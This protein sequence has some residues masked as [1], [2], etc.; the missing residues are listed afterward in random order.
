M[1]KSVLLIAS[2][3]AHPPFLAVWRLRALVRACFP[4]VLSVHSLEA[5]AGLDLSKISA[6]VLYFHHQT[7]SEAALQAFERFVSCGGG[8]LALHSATASFK[9]C[10]RYTQILGGRFTGHG[11]IA[12][13][14][15]YPVEGENAPFEGLG[16]FAVQDEL[17]LH[18]LQ[19]GIRVH[20]EARLEG[21]LIPVVWTYQYGAGRVCYA[22]PGHTA[23]SLK[24]PA[25]RAILRCGLEWVATGP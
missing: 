23:G 5:L 11:A 10:P 19:P 16:G 13:F 18:D 25:Y 9:S 6:L 3:L 1:K 24:N 22:V 15:V 17:Y 12:P 21:R 20:F 2:G 7:I 14:Q 4:H 8:V